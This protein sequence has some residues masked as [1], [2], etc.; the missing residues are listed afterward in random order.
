MGV[1]AKI[2]RH[3]EKC[4]CAGARTKFSIAWC[5]LSDAYV[6]LAH[7]V[8]MI[9][10]VH[11]VCTHIIMACVVCAVLAERRGI[12]LVHVRCGFILSHDSLINDVRGVVVRGGGILKFCMVQCVE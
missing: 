5:G 3:V 6:I 8:H 1:H 12:L 2:W 4:W 11:V 7:I 9:N 10:K